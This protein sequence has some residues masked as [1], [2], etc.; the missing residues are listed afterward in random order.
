MSW[1]EMV[2]AH[3]SKAGAILVGLLV[4]YLI[5]EMFR[6]LADERNRRAIGMVSR[7]SLLAAT[8]AAQEMWS[9]LG[10]AKTPDSPGGKDVTADEIKAIER[11]GM[12]RGWQVIKEQAPSL[13]KNIIA[14][15]GGEDEVKQAMLVR[16]RSTLSKVK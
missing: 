5:P 4:T 7:A 1:W 14:I 2:L 11:V 8:A 13:V 3:G 10:K 15:Y 16:I 9:A 6:L 12:E